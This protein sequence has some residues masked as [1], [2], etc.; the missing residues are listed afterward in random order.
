VPTTY[1]VRFLRRSNFEIVRTVSM[2]KLGLSRAT[3][4][5]HA[6]RELVHA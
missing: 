6:A 2:V 5:E 3:D 1:Y 4:A